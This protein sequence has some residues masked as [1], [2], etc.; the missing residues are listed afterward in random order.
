MWQ[1][2]TDVSEVGTAS[3]FTV[4]VYANQATSNWSEPLLDFCSLLI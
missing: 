2:F 3:I 4:E 1:K